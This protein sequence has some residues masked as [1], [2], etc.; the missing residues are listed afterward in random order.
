MTGPRPTVLLVEDDH[1]TR[2]V[3]GY[4]LALEG[5]AVTAL[6]DGGRALEA[7]RT[8][9]PDLVLLDLCLPGVGGREVVGAMRNEPALADVPVVSI[10]AASRESQPATISAHVQK[11]FGVRELLEAVAGALAAPGG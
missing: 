4:V 11:P 5:Y 3:L 2:E 7:M 8:R 9:R 6:A 10:S 1:D